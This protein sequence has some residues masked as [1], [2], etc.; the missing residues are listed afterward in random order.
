MGILNVTTD[1][2][3]DGGKFFKFEDAKR[4]A[5]KMAEEGADIIDIGGESTRPGSEAVPLEEELERVI[6]LIEDLVKSTSIPI[7]ID[8]YKSEVAQRALDA[9]AEII[10]DISALRFDQ[11]MADMAAGY[12]AGIVLM[13]IQGTPK[14][15]QE[16]PHYDNL[17]EEIKTYLKESIK[18]AEQ[19]GVKKDKIVIDPGIGFGKKVEHNLNILRNLKEFGELGKP[20]M[21]G[22]SRKSFIGKLLDLPVEQRLEG[23]LAGLAVSIMNGA[24]LVRVHDVKESLRV[25]RLVDTIIRN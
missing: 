3:S 12:D 13:H 9:G 15:M 10:N 22:T 6:P 4:Q 16:N 25:V 17:I 14:N 11:N 21:V 2:F 19:A 7:S 1:S 23:S 20:I 24:N 18:L 5:L 8:T